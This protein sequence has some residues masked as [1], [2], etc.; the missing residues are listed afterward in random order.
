MPKKILLGILFSTITVAHSFTILKTRREVEHVASLVVR[1]AVPIKKEPAGV[2]HM[3]P[4]PRSLT[5]S[6]QK[7][8]QQAKHMVKRGVKALRKRKARGAREDTLNLSVDKLALP[9]WA[10]TDIEELCRLAAMKELLES[11]FNM[12]RAQSIRTDD[13]TYK[14]IVD[15][16]PDVYGDFRLL[17]FLRKDKVQNPKSAATRYRNF[18]E[19]REDFKVDDV[20]QRVERKPFMPPH[21]LQPVED[22]IPCEFDVSEGSHPE[23]IAA[24]LHVGSWDTTKLT[25]M[26]RKKELSLD[27]FLQYW[28]YIFES[29]NSKLHEESMKRGR[30]VYVDEI[31]DLRN[32]N[33]RQFSPGFVSFVLKPWLRLTQQNYPETT[34]RIFFLNPPRIIS[35]VWNIVTPM[36][37]P[38]TIAKVQFRRAYKRS[39]HDFVREL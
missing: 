27:D 11:D 23:T 36:A 39:C 5:P 26:I 7:G 28:T 10:C 13:G 16:F 29:L 33:M 38:G 15:A 37:S 32:M 6:I 3:F 4:R 17:R 2:A 35:V 9:S 1:N 22:L 21:H 25:D 31:C 12:L 18:L 19:W 8:G 14:N 24:L 30:M 20:R 34:K